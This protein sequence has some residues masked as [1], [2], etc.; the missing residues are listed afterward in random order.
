MHFSWSSHYIFGN[1]VI[2]ILCSFSIGLTFYHRSTNILY[3]S[4]SESLIKWDMDLQLFFSFSSIVIFSLLIISFEVQNFSAL[5]KCNI[6]LLL[7]VLSVACLRNHYPTQKAIKI[8]G[9]VFF[10][11]L[12]RVWALT[13]SLMIHF[14]LIFSVWYVMY[15]FHICTAPFVRDCPFSME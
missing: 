2:Q 7:L 4:W 15:P 1:N 5:I 9:Y 13:F 10:S 11:L 14:E 12:A 8:Y 3:I 6:F